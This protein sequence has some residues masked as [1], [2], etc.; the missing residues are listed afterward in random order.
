MELT[1]WVRR[2]RARVKAGRLAIASEKKRDNEKQGWRKKNSGYRKIGTNDKNKSFNG[3]S[4][5]EPRWE[6]S[7][8]VWQT[9]I[10]VNLLAATGSAMNDFQQRR[11][12]RFRHLRNIT[13]IGGN[14]FFSLSLSICNMKLHRTELLGR[15]Q[16]RRQYQRAI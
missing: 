14:A 6:I 9:N 12:L 4:V 2:E 11:W 5:L 15:S 7:S 10:A 3:I 1:Y 8:T 13:E 16:V